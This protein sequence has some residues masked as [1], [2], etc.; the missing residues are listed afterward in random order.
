[1]AALWLD[2]RYA[3][4]M[5]VKAPG[6]TALLVITLALGVGATTTIFSVVHAVILRPLPYEQPDR[7]VRIYTEFTGKFTLKQLGVSVTELD[8]LRTACRSCASVAGWRDASASLAGGDRPVHVDIAY[9]TPELLPMLGV[10]PLL[11]RWFDARDDRPGDPEVIVLGYGVWQRAFAADPQIIGRTLHLDTMPV[12]VIGVMPKGFEFLDRREA[13]VPGGFRPSEAL[14]GAHQLHAVVRLA[15][16]AE[17]AALQA[18]LAALITQWAAKKVPNHHAIGPE[19]PM[20]AVAFQADL[21]GSLSTMLWMLQGAVLFVLS[22]AIVNIANL[23]LARSEARTREVAVRH[24][25]GASRR[26]LFRQFATE[27]LVLGICGGTLGILVAV[28]ALDAVTALIPA[29][30]PRASEIALDGAAVGFAVIC[31]IAAALVFGV[32]PI[33]HARRIDLH[34]ALK[35]SS[36]RVTGSRLRRR[37]RSALVI[38]EIALAVVLVTGCA[39]MVRSF[40]RLQHVELG[41]RPERLLTFGIELPDRAYPDAQGD[42]FWRRHAE[43]MRALPGVTGVALIDGMMPLRPAGIADV[44]LLGRTRTP[45][46]PEWVVDY[47]EVVGDRSLT[48]LGARIVRGRDIERRDDAGAP[49]V[50]AINEAFAARFFPHEDPIG[51]QLGLIFDPSKPATIIGVV[52][53]I[54]QAGVD[55]PAG[56]E[57]FIPGAQ[58][59]SLFDPPRSKRSLYTLLRSDGDP[60]DLVPAVQRAVAEIDPALPV[61][62]LRTM[63]DVLWEA[64]ARPRF[65]T[66]LL[67]SFAALA[68]V[69]AAVGVYGVM[70]QSVAQR[71]HEIG[72]RV[73]LGAQPR[74]VRAMVLRQASKLVAAGIALGL[75]TALALERLLADPLHRMYRDDL[76]GQ[77]VLLGAVVLAVSAMAM[78][79][80]WIPARRATQVEPTVALRSE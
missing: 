38:A 55:R 5:M 49:R 15:P 9:A 1:M 14:R 26:R 18:E 17:L 10:H 13:W 60:A 43:R 11:G 48:M 37:V 7:L 53:D 35:D 51:Q 29:S 8:E 3:L 69:L 70:A 40:L 36:S 42:V 63:D 71:T 56:T 76:P 2:L 75:A 12:T 34:G 33:L 45:D 61:F 28:W 21:V 80:T 68:L 72:L 31:S 58:Y 25:L 65:L 74:Q 67:T 77:P 50:V 6:L 32:A 59:A 41:F 47:M 23:L 30:A 64:V 78:L 79:A 39:V 4:R 16:G 57:V 24:A 66:W 19:H 62:D 20:V 46:G 22:I 73:A 27:S 54:K 44:W 52:A